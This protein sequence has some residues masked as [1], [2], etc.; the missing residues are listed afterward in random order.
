[1]K[2]P[3]NSI[4][5]GFHIAM[6][7]YQ[8]VLL[9]T[10]YIII[11]P[12]F[13]NYILSISH[14]LPHHF[15]PPHGLGLLWLHGPPG[16]CKGSLHRR[17]ADV[18]GLYP[19]Q[20]RHGIPSVDPMPWWEFPNFEK[21]G[22]LGN[23]T[24]RTWEFLGI[25]PVSKNMPARNRKQCGEQKDMRLVVVMMM[26]MMMMM[27]VEHKSQVV[28]ELKGKMPDPN[29]TRA[30][31]RGNLQEKCRAP[32]PHTSFCMEIYR[33]DAHEHFTRA[34]FVCKFYR[35]NAAHPFRG[36]RFAR[37]CAAI[38]CG[39]L[40]EVCRTP[41][42]T[43]RLNTGPFTRT[44]RTPSVCP[45]CLG[46]NTKWHGFIYKTKE[47]EQRH[48]GLWDWATG[49]VVVLQPAQQLHVKRKF[50][51]SY[52]PV[53]CRT[54]N[55]ILIAGISGT[56]TTVCET[57]GHRSMFRSRK[58]TFHPNLADLRPLGNLSIA[59]RYSTLFREPPTAVIPAR[60]TCVEA[61]CWVEVGTFC[62]RKI[63]THQLVLGW[64]WLRTL[65]FGII[66]DWFWYG[67][68]SF[69]NT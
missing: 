36:P 11:Q 38:F 67:P 57:F 56:T 64:W 18:Q 43:P 4:C 22:N 9:T 16:G 15:D 1:M 61:T 66:W 51:D 46:K 28:Q 55:G 45:R 60:L 6:F 25:G 62:E 65:N 59:P 29:A 58:L 23:S 69:Y 8:D 42:W 27:I 48:V 26:M 30:I 44:V 49:P 68:S 3:R 24:F 50:C 53:G 13:A 12:L 7:D 37:A 14:L 47:T 39:N 52:Q 33:K 32:I 2:S 40:Q 31:L 20:G 41:R 10:S 54:V 17:I 21:L 63:R 35:T 34:I 19:C 5:G